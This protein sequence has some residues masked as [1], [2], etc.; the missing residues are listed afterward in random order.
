[1]Y[2]ITFLNP[3]NTSVQLEVHAGNQANCDQNGT[4]FNSSLGANGTY[5]LDTSENVVCWRRTANPGTPGSPLG[6]WGTFA[7]D[8][9]NTP[10]T[11]QL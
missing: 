5:V 2:S 9:I 11:I 7:P 8:N 6:G 3:F 10:T 1:M 4:T